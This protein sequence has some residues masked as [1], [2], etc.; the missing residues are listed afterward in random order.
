MKAMQTNAYSWETKIEPSEE[1]ATHIFSDRVKVIC[2]F[3]FEI[4]T[5]FRDGDPIAKISFADKEMP[6]SEYQKI[7][8]G[9][10]RTAEAAKDSSGFE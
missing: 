1:T 4:I 10:A 3:H 5:I 6:V 9:V 8:L 7:L 2:D